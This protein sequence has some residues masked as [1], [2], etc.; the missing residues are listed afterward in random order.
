MWYSFQWRFLIVFRQFVGIGELLDELRMMIG[1]DDGLLSAHGEDAAAALVVEDAG[2]LVFA[3]HV[4]LVSADD[5]TADLLRLLAA[6]V[7]HA[8]VGK[9]RVGHAEFEFQLEIGGLSAAPDQKRVVLAG[10]S[11]VRLRR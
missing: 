6:A 11:A 10:F 4:G 7:L 1:A 5:P 8:G 2:V 9:A 3:V